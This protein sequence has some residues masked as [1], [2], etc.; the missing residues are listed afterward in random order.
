MNHHTEK[1]QKQIEILAPAGS[2]ASLEAALAAGADAIYAGGMRF[3]A[4][5]YAGNLSEEEYLRAIDEVHLQQ[6]KIYMTVNTLLKDQELGELYDYLLPYY[7]QGLDAVIVQDPGVFSFIRGV[8]PDLPIH[9]S[10]QMTVTGSYGAEFF[11][12][13]GAQRIVPA[14][15][16]NLSEIREMKEKTGLEIECFVHGAMCYCYSG[17]CLMSSMIGGRSGNRGQCAQPCRL[18]YAVDGKKPQDIMSLK[19]L[20]TIEMIPDLVDAGIDS[21]K[22]EGRM[23]QPEYVYTVARMYRKYA[24]LYLQ[25]GR[26]GF[27]V[28]PQDLK[29]L[30]S[31][32]TRRG[33]M[34][35]YYQ[36]ENLS[37]IHI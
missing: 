13:H 9:V 32:Y 31:A 27:H 30:Q 20:C 2:Y 29:I 16:I 28:D 3:G 11:G 14:R 5:A 7:R 26:K 21:F 18:P 15:E 19:D 17:Q 33:Y 35:G 8:F 24:D 1:E 25:E 37:L 23:K 4:R 10:T 22:I 34:K 36:C 6:K 12:K